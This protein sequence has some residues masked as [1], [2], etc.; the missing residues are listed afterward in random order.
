[1]DNTVAKPTDIDDAWWDRLD[2]II[3]QWM[4]GTITTEL[5][6]KILDDK[7][8]AMQAWERLRNIFQDNKG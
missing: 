2:A 7:S 5:L 6:L 1:M 4:Y 8:T 3:C